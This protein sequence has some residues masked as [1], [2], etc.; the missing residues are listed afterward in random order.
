[1]RT[2][3]DQ[4]L[5][6]VEDYMQRRAARDDGVHERHHPPVFLVHAMK[7]DL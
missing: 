3:V 2:R 5:D 6:F 7:T 1:M 4:H